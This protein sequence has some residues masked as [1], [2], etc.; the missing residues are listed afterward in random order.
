[1]LKIGL[2]GG[3]GS[4]KSTVSDIF[5]VLG[6]PVYNADKQAKTLMEQDPGLRAK[7]TDLFGPEAY[8]G[9]QLNRKWIAD[10]VFND[11]YQLERLNAIVHPAAISAGEA[12]A[13]EQN[14][15]YVVKEAALFFEAGSAAGLDYIIGVYTPKHLRIQRVMQRDGLSRDAVLQR[16]AQQIQEEIKMRLCDFVIVNDEQQLLIPQV[17]RLHEQFIKES[18]DR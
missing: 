5:R 15:A 11:R 1:M 13:L 2:T 18:Y 10:I 9:G 3:I 8:A 6:I 16:M 7:V 4:G 12:W 17:L 14:T